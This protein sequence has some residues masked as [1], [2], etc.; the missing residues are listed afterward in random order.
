MVLFDKDE[1]NDKGLKIKLETESTLTLW[2]EG[3]QPKHGG[4]WGN[5]LPSDLKHFDLESL[6]F[7]LKFFELKSW[8][9]TMSTTKPSFAI[10][11]LQN[12]YALKLPYFF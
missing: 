3:P 12:F 10:L 5:V 4:P 8:N 1:A 9:C 7:S 11:S 2:S 6:F